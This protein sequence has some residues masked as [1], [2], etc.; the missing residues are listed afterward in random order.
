MKK[1]LLTAACIAA[2]TASFAKGMIQI[3]VGGLTYGSVATTYDTDGNKTDGSTTKY[4]TTGTVVKVG[5]IDE[6]M[7][8]RYELNIPGTSSV[9]PG[10][11]LTSASK[12]IRGGYAVMPNSLYVTLGFGSKN[13]ST[14]DDDDNTTFLSKSTDVSLGLRWLKYMQKS[15]LDLNFDVAYAVN[16]KNSIAAAVGATTGWTFDFGVDYYYNVTDR[17][18]IGTG[19]ALSYDMQTWDIKDQEKDTDASGFGWEIE[20]LK[21]VSTYKVYLVWVGQRLTLFFFFELSSV[22][23]FFPQIYPH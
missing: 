7:F 8:L 15:T 2:P 19:V 5:A 16:E 11:P 6:K 12:F 14:T 3:D 23:S 22:S 13:V 20:L 17:A 9:I 10:N 18:L 4:G 1:V 21:V